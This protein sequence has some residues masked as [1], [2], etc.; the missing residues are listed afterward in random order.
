MKQNNKAKKNSKNKKPK[1]IKISL[2]QLTQLTEAIRASNLDPTIG[3]MLID[4]ISGNRWL[5]TALEKGQLSIKQL[6][7]YLLIQKKEF[8]PNGVA[9]KAIE[10]VLKRWTELTQFLR[11][12]NVPLDNNLT[13]RALKLIIQVRKSSMFYKTLK[14]AKIASYIQ[15]AL[16]SAAQN[17]V[18]PHHYMQAILDNKY[19]VINNPDAWL[20]W[21]F[22][23]TSAGLEPG[24]SRHDGC[25]RQDCP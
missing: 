23:A 5:V 17:D 10:Y 7:A 18:N 22:Q 20:P 8:E 1:I 3:E 12:T 21:N 25:M 15:T 24:S 14:I 4:N 16:Y 11:H 2:E 6:R 19:A 9:G 13:E